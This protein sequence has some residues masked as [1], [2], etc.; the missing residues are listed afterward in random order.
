MRAATVPIQRPRDA[1]L[2]TVDRYGRID[3]HPRTAF[4]DLLRPGDCVIA[5]DAATLPASLHGVHER[6]GN[7]IEV[8]LAGR[9]SLAGGDAMNRFSAIVFGT[10]DFHTLTEE[11]A[12]PPDLHRGDRLRFGA[13]GATI[14]RLLGHPRFVE[15]HFDGDA[16]QVW[17]TLASHGKPVQYAHLADPLAL[18][19][20]W[21][22]IAAQPVAF[23]PP[24]AGFVLDWST[25][26]ALHARGVPFATLT[27]AAGLSSTGDATLDLRLPLD[28]P[29]RIPAATAALVKATRAG[30]GR[31]VAIG[32][33]VVRALEHAAATDGAV[34]PGD[35][36]ATQRIGPHTRLRAV[37]VI[38]SGTHEPDSSHYALLRAFADASTLARVTATLEAHRY[39]THE[40][41]DSMWVERSMDAVREEEHVYD[42]RQ[43]SW[44]AVPCD[45]S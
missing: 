5:N 41:G 30:G 45:L 8:R 29:Y 35:G 15:L 12:A 18:W 6:S 40:F 4:A 39:R 36:I 43:G 2:L 34:H 44:V 31:V 7:V 22:P 10:G 11:R 13:D 33:T 20:V 3:E 21:T 32:T 1:R 27:H 28:E 14:V 26:D 25:L 19:D 17:R 37:D 16:A 24:S 23:E 42:E 38:V 9:T